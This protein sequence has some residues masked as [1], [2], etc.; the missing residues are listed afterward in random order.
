MNGETEA[1]GLGGDPA[2]EFRIIVEMILNNVVALTSLLF[3]PRSI[4]DLNR[5]SAVFDELCIF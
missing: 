2:F 5:P 4:K 1:P 3:E